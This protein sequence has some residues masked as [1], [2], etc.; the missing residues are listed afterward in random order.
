MFK[1]LYDALRAKDLLAPAVEITDESLVLAGRFTEQVSGGLLLGEPVELDVMATDQ[2]INAAEIEVRR[3]V[4]EHLVMQP[5]V[6]LTTSVIL[7]S[8]I[9]D[10][11]RIG[12]YAKNIDQ[13][14]PRL[15]GAWPTGGGFDHLV[16]Y[17]GELLSLF[18][19]TIETIRKGDVD[20]GTQVMD[21][22]H[23]LGRRCE[24][25]VDGFCR[26]EKVLGCNAVVGSLTAR[27]FKRI[28]AHLSNLASG[29]VNP[30]DRIGFEPVRGD[31]S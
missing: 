9:G 14:R 20:L 5:S 25:L 27:Y 11:E 30:I 17:R 2:Q 3:M 6:D 10:V 28:S 31:G 29:V 21:R 4:F 1:S 24:D 18:D 13:L 22:Q 7:L 16:M 19:D 23:G 8:T 12:D 15:R 26:D